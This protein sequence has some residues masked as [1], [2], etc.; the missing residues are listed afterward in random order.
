MA[1]TI[2][3]VERVLR[4]LMAAAVAFLLLGSCGGHAA[5]SSAGGSG[6][7]R[8]VA[9]E[10]FYG[11]IASQVGGKHVAITSILSDPN[12]DPH[13]YEPGTANAAAVAGADVV[14]VNGLG[15]DAFMGRLLRAAPNGERRVVSVARAL[16][17]TGSGVNP[18]IWYDVPRLHDIAS[19]IS[20]GLASVDPA[21]KT[22][23]RR[24]LAHFDASLRPLTNAVSRIRSRYGGEAV[25]YTEPVPGYLLHAAGLEVRTPDAFAV[26]IE[27]GNEPTP[28]AVAVMDALLENKRVRVLI[29]N[30]QATS[31]IT[32]GLRRL[33]RQHGIPIVPVTETLPPHTTFQQWQIDQVRSLER[34]LAG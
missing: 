26:A 27:E 31:P 7:I 13:L 20:Q 12:A 15:Y 34:A 25:A 3:L 17:M 28:Q 19:A 23:F 4:R 29:Y 8:V 1:F 2:E 24:A 22:S 11:D 6:P 14:I 5:G 9:A 30:A 21:H 16:H 33:A 18:H 10:N 32:D